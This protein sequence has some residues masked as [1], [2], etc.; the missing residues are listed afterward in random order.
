MKTENNKLIAK[1]M[2]LEIAFEDTSYPCI[3]GKQNAWTPIKYDK[4]WNWLMQVVEKIDTVCGIGL[5]EWDEYIN[6]ALCSK[7]I[8]TTYNAC[9]EFIKWYNENSAKEN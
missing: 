8:E 3:M 7:S 5:H 2:D 6:G 4:D 9:V 1:F